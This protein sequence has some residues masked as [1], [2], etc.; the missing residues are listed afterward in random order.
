MGKGT[1]PVLVFGWVAEWSCSGLQ[2]RGRRSDSGLSLQINEN[3]Y[4]L[5]PGG[6]IGRRKGLKIPRGQLRAGS[7]PAPGTKYKLLMRSSRNETPIAFSLY[8][9][10]SCKKNYKK[11]SIKV[12]LSP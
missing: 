11:I 4:P 9:H 3:Q 1:I 7:S 2:S 10:R 5:S 8:K 12:K 6:E